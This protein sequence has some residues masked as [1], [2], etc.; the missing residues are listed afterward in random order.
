MT[1]APD[2]I[3]TK[4]RPGSFDEVVG[5]EESVSALERHLKSPSQSHGY[6]LSGPSGT[7]KTTLARIIAKQ[8]DCNPEEIDA[9]MFSGVD[10]MRQLIASGSYRSLM[11]SGRRMFV[12]NEVQRLSK[13]AFDALLTTLEEPPSHLYFALTTTEADKVPDAVK[14]RSYEVK[15]RS[16]GAGDIESLLIAV[17]SAEKW[18]V[19]DE[20][21]E[22]V[23]EAAHG[24][25]RQALSMLQVV[26]DV[27]S[28]DEVKRIIALSDVSSEP[29]IEICQLMLRGVTSANSMRI[30][31][32]LGKID[33]DVFE[34]ALTLAA[35]YIMGAM[36]RSR[37]DREARKAWVLLDALL[38]PASTFDKKAALYCAI[39]RAI[40]GGAS[41]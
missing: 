25:P 20:T 28:R 23:V 37:T 8:L 34:Q 17:A 38:F 26:H 32:L 29:L 1:A 22:A 13:G 39:G 9:A 3:I 33:D 5:N 16:V 10:A 18:D 11:T 24:S 21:F 36:N 27:R 40:W 35:R 14:T 7:G 19:L 4:Y 31:E 15:L 30:V 2:T 12:I 6:L 41:V